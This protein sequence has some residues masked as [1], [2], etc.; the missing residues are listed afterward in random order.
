MELGKWDAFDAEINIRLGDSIT[1][2][3]AQP[4]EPPGVIDDLEDFDFE[5]EENMISLEHVIPAAD[6]VGSTGKPINQ[7]LM[8]DFLINAEVLLG[9]GDT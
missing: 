6:S 1:L 2:P 4:Q 3:Q 8:T 9:Q 7:Q 5:Y